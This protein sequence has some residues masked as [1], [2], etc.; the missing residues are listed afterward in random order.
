MVKKRTIAGIDIGTDKVCTIIASINEENGDCNVIG[1]AST[2]SKGLR[3]SQI[4]DLEE[5]MGAITDSVE[6]AERMAG[7]NINEAFVS[8]SGAHISSQNSKGVVAVSE[9]QGEISPVDVNRVIEAARAIALPSAREIIHVVPRDYSVDAQ[10]GIKDPVGMTGVRLEAEA[11][12]ITGSQTA[13]KNITKCVADLGISVQGLIFSGLASANSVLSETEKELGVV[14]VDIGGGSI[15]L[16]SYIEGALTYSSVIPIGAKNITNDLAI[17]MRISLQSAE[18]IK[19]YLSKTQSSYTPAASSKPAEIAKYRKDFDVVDLV[20]LGI[21][22]DT[23]QASRKALIEGIIRPRLNEIFS[24][25]AS[26]LKENNLI[27]NIPAGIVITGGGAETVS[28][29][30]VAKRTLGVPARVGSPKGLKGLVDE[31]KSPSFATAS[32]LILYALKDGLYSNTSPVSSGGRHLT[33]LIPKFNL[34]PIYQ[35]AL[36]FIKSHLP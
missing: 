13:M 29:I 36:S 1:V 34:Q 4:V 10:T 35:K 30:E 18:T 9:P 17:G 27:K 12:L 11:H 26:Q 19:I 21:K 8:I 23:A 32:G 33:S 7:F 22:E 2:P 28:L 6:A 15:A 5:A 25:I 20:K 31:L 3:K 16:T 14:L 24:L